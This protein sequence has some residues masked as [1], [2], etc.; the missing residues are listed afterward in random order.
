LS[1]NPQDYTLPVP[2]IGPPP[3]PDTP[4]ANRITSKAG[5]S[6]Q[7]LI[8]FS[9]E[10][11]V[12]PAVTLGIV[13]HGENYG[14]Q[15]Y[16]QGP[17]PKGARGSGQ[18]M[19]KT[20]ER[21]GKA[22]GVHPAEILHNPETNDRATV[23]EIKR[24]LTRNR[25]HEDPIGATAVGYNA[26]EGEIGRYN[27]QTG[28]H[29]FKETREYAARVKAALPQLDS[30]M[31][32]LIER[33]KNRPANSTKTTPGASPNTSVQTPAQGPE[34]PGV[35]M[36]P[37][38]GGAQTP[39]S[40]TPMRDTGSSR[41][42]QSR[43]TGT[44]SV[45]SI[46]EP[47]PPG[48][49]PSNRVTSGPPSENLT[50]TGPLP[51]P[52]I[53]QSGI[54]AAAPP[55]ATPAP[56]PPPATPER[57]QRVKARID[58]LA[59]AM[60]RLKPTA[61]EGGQASGIVYQ[62]LQ[63]EHN[64]LV[65][66]HNA[67]LPELNAKSQMK[68]G[69]AA[70]GTTRTAEPSRSSILANDAI[71][72]P[73]TGQSN[74][75]ETD[76]PATEDE[77]YRNWYA[78]RQSGDRTRA[79]AVGDA[80]LKYYPNGKYTR[81][82][83]ESRLTSEQRAQTGGAGGQIRVEEIE[84]LRKSGLDDATILTKVQDHVMRQLG[85]KDDEIY[86]LTQ[87]YGHH[88]LA[89][90]V[91]GGTDAAASLNSIIEQG[92][93][94]G[95]LA[96]F[97]VL[98]ETMQELARDK[99]MLRPGDAM[100][101]QAKASSPHSGFL[102]FLTEVGTAKDVPGPIQEAALELANHP[103]AIGVIDSLAAGGIK[104]GAEVFQGAANL[105]HFI[106][107][108][109]PAGAVTQAALQ[110][111]SGQL[112]DMGVNLG[113]QGG[114]PNLEY[115]S[116]LLMHL[117]RAYA[118]MEAG[119]VAFEGVAAP[120]EAGTALATGAETTAPTAERMLY[121]GIGESPHI[122]ST[123]ALGAEGAAMQGHKGTGPAVI[124]GLLSAGPYGVAFGEAGSALG[125]A[126]RDTTTG[127][128]L[129][130]EELAARA[131]A[132]GTKQE[133]INAAG[134]FLARKLTAEVT[135][136]ATGEAAK[137]G[138]F[139]ATSAATIAA[140]EGRPM[141]K[142]ELIE[143][144][145]LG[146]GLGIVP[147]IADFAGIPGEVKGVKAEAAR[148]S[149][150]AGIFGAKDVTRR[151]PERQVEGEVPGTDL[152]RRAGEPPAQPSSK[153]NTEGISKPSPVS[154]SGVAPVEGA[155]PPSSK[156]SSSAGA[157]GAA[158]AVEESGGGTAVNPPPTSPFKKET[159]NV[160]DQT[161]ETKPGETD[162]A[163]KPPSIEAGSE[164]S[165]AEAP[166][167]KFSSTQVNLS[168]PV[169]K[170]ITRLAAK[171]PDQDLAA[172]GREEEPHITV[173]Y[174]LHGDDAEAVR[175]V[176]ANEPPIK[177]KL[178]STSIFPGKN[179]ADYD[180]V[181]VDV[182]SPD[183][184]RLNKMIAALPHTDTHPTYQ[185]HITLA[186]VKPGLGKKY[187]GD[188][189]LEGKEV[190]LD[191][192]VFWDTEDG[193]T[194]IKLKG[195]AKELQSTAA[196]KAAE[197]PVLRKPTDADLEEL[198]RDV[199]ADVEKPAEKPAVAAPR[200]Y[201]ASGMLAAATSKAKPA[202]EA[203]LPPVEKPA[204]KPKTENQLKRAA[205]I[206]ELKKH[207][208]EGATGGKS[209]TAQ[210]VAYHT[211]QSAEWVPDRQ[212]L[213]L[214]ATGGQMLDAVRAHVGK[215]TQQKAAG[216]QFT[217][218]TAALYSR[219]AVQIAKT[220]TGQ[221][222]LDLLKLANELSRA[223]K[224]AKEIVAVVK[225]GM[226]TRETLT[227]ERIHKALGLLFREHG[228]LIPAEK[229]AKLPHYDAIN[230][231]LVDKGYD[232]NPHVMSVEAITHIGAGQ[233]EQLGITLEQ[234]SDFAEGYF[235]LVAETYGAKWLD[236]FTSLKGRYAAIKRRVQ[237]QSGSG[238]GVGQ[239]VSEGR[240]RGIEGVHPE[241]G[242]GGEELAWHASPYTFDRFTLDHIGEGEGAQS[243]GWGLYFAGAKEVGQFYKEKFQPGRGSSP[244]DIAGRVLDSIGRDRPNSKV[245]AVKEL[246][247]RADRID[248]PVFK[249]TMA[250][251][252]AAV[253][254]GTASARLYKVDLAPKEEDYLLW[255]APLYS[256]S[257]KVQA[258]LKGA[259]HEIV[260][261]KHLS[262]AQL[263]DRSTRFFYSGRFKT[264]WA[265]DIG[266]RDSLR[267]AADAYQAGKDAFLGYLE[268]AEGMSFFDNYIL[269]IGSTTGEQFYHKLAQQLEQ[270]RTLGKA[271]LQWSAKVSDP[272]AASKRLLSLGIKGIKYLDQGSRSKGEGSHN[273]VIFDG[274]DIA[275]QS[276]ED[277]VPP[278]PKQVAMMVKI[279]ASYVD[280]GITDF[281]QAAEQFQE[282]YGE[283]SRDLDRHLEL[284]WQK[285]K[286]RFYP[287]ISDAGRVADILKTKPKTADHSEAFA[288]SHP[289]WE[290]GGQAP[291]KEVPEWAKTAEGSQRHALEM[292]ARAI[293][294]ANT[295]ILK[296][297]ILP[298]GKPLT[299]E[300]RTQM[301]AENGHWR[302]VL[303][304]PAEAV[305][306]AVLS[307]DKKE[308]S[309][310]I[311]EEGKPAEAPPPAN[312]PT[313]TTAPE[314]LDEAVANYQRTTPAKG[315]PEREAVAG[316]IHDIE[317]SAKRPTKLPPYGPRR[318]AYMKKEEARSA[319]DAARVKELRNIRGRAVLE[320]TVETG[321]PE[322]QL[323]AL[324]QLKG[325]D[326]YDELKP[327]AKKRLLVEG[328]SEEAATREA[329][330][331]A[332]EVAQNP[333]S[334]TYAFSAA[335]D[336]AVTRARRTEAH[337]ELDKL[338]LTGS[339]RQKYARDIDRQFGP[340]TKILAKAKAEVETRDK[341]ARAAKKKE[342]DEQAARRTRGAERLKTPLSDEDRAAIQE[343]QKL[344]E[345]IGVA[346]EQQAKNPQSTIKPSMRSTLAERGLIERGEVTAKG[347]R[348]LAA[349]DLIAAGLPISDYRPGA[350]NLPKP[351]AGWMTGQVNGAKWYTD[352]HF[353]MKGE[354]PKGPLA[355]RSPDMQ[356]MVPDE[357]KGSMTVIKPIGFSQS[358]RAQ[359]EAIWFNGKI[360]AQSA[361][362]DHITKK[363]KAIEWRSTNP[364]KS[365]RPIYGY[366][367]G[368]LVAVLMPLRIKDVPDV[369]EAIA[370]GAPEPKKVTKPKAK[371]PAPPVVEAAPE[372]NPEITEQPNP[373]A[374]AVDRHAAALDA[375]PDNLT[376]AEHKAEVKRIE[377][378]FNEATKEV[379][380]EKGTA[381]LDL[382]PGPDQDSMLAKILNTYADEGI[383]TFE[384]ALN[385]F[386]GDYGEGARDLEPE[387][388]AA[389]QKLKE[390]HYSTRQPR[391]EEGHF[392]GSPEETGRSGERGAV[393][394]DV[395]GATDAAEALKKVA[396]TIRSGRDDFRNL[397]NPSVRG[398]AARHTAL[399]V[400]ERAADRQRSVDQ[401]TKAVDDLRNKVFAK[402]KPA[403]NYMFIDRMEHG[404]GQ[405]S[406]DL[407]V[408]SGM[409]RDIM[410]TDRQ[411]VQDLGTG[412]LEHFIENYY[413]RYWEKRK[414]GPTPAAQG[415]AKAPLEGPKSFTKRRSYEYFMDGIAAGETPLSDNP[416]DFLLWKHAEMQKYIESH[417]NLN[418][419][420]SDGMAIFAHTRA[421]APEGW[422]TPKDNLFAVW[423]RGE[424]GELI[425]R[426]HYYL[427]EEA[428]RIFDNYTSQGLRNK[429]W[430]RGY[431]GAANL[432]NQM[433]LGLSFYHAG[434]VSLDSMISNFALGIYQLTHGNPIQAAKTAAQ[435][436]VAPFTYVRMGRRMRKQW[437]DP[438]TH[439]ELEPIVDAWIAGG[440]RSSM[441]RFYHTEMSRKMAD[442]FKQ[443][444]LPGLVKGLLRA[445]FALVE[446]VAWPVMEWMVPN[447]KAGAVGKMAEYE[448][449]R[450]GPDAT[451]E[452]IRD[453]MAKV[454]DSVDN[455]M[456]QMIYDNLFWNK[457]AK[458]LGM[459][460]VR[461][462][463][464]NIGDIREVGGGGV[465]ALIA[466]KRIATGKAPE[467]T[468]RM[469]YVLALP[470]IVGLIG[471]V[472][473]YLLT[474]KGPK[475]LK[476]YFY[477]PTGN[478]DENG[479]P[480]RIQL[481]SYVKDLYPLVT[482]PGIGGKITKAG[483]M[484]QHKIHPLLNTLFE[485]YRNKDFFGTEI[486]NEDDPFV[487]QAKD[488]LAHVA[489]SLSPLGVRGLMRERERG[490]S[491][492][493]QALPM[494]GITPA[495]RYVNQTTTQ[496]LMEEYLDSVRP[497]GVR[498]KA[499]AEALAIMREIARAERSGKPV[500]QAKV[501]K[502][503]AD[504]VLKPDDL[505]EATRRGRLSTTQSLFQ[506]LPYEKAQQIY[507]GAPE[508]E[509]RELL[510]LLQ[511]K[512][513]N[514]NQSGSTGARTPSVPSIMRGGSHAPSPSHSG[515][516][517]ITR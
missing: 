306:V 363:Y 37:E 102:S 430:F 175:K 496:Q 338:D 374:E 76:V 286:E 353:M 195:T 247:N 351:Y 222:K 69:T 512:L 453:A 411:Q 190:T 188:A 440:G 28:Y 142:E 180:V 205:L 91:K 9:L 305:K 78:A 343:F 456:G 266:I 448:L 68:G 202:K 94:N 49:Q 382:M 428:V 304:E 364:D 469:S 475:E 348:L 295:G 336:R 86:A 396:A 393:A 468:H 8:H 399:M 109:T 45:P 200:N 162:K 255:D 223:A 395:L 54:F 379:E 57:L 149:N 412:K 229:V 114:H 310:L 445:P 483:E 397:F 390:P 105:A 279:L 436:A 402:A 63:D 194:E 414:T 14:K 460:T 375:I 34:K 252:I 417:R 312:K 64:R 261:R 110:T 341:E 493:K 12:D 387:L 11:G 497:Q 507:D 294:H 372:T 394:A 288:A 301:E 287:D 230:L 443:G 492:I 133:A 212:V 166:E 131:L 50:A 186:Y 56:R 487:Q 204:E 227:H 517:R 367:K 329:N 365:D 407:N 284:A 444:T 316:E 226:A 144:A 15:K 473:T 435:T 13:E 27:S 228:R 256:Q 233:R 409:F 309:R 98:P 505:K 145:V 123:L 240:T 25:D 29:P 155:T 99:A 259:G 442:A 231:G 391:T 211:G 237:E 207:R 191:S 151:G 85:W 77:F 160:S 244:K 185:P 3:A 370:E 429:L 337:G 416:V 119:G 95:G 253:R 400:R 108:G 97:R 339:Q 357:A 80:Y 218:Q 441:D 197:K 262:D 282:D 380:P 92:N 278:D 425:Q 161:A 124:G 463:G 307:G 283:G 388:E 184:H 474:G 462:L 513:Q 103:D 330:G 129:P 381:L 232:D 285:L 83:T 383:E 39:T 504:G 359:F 268:T 276:M 511:K 128:I 134:R 249:K 210:G 193:Q 482:Q 121:E 514:Q 59:G 111:L 189:S 457:A 53:T 327:I 43:I 265:E 217:N 216:S 461:S 403:D 331:V 66:A 486:R 439:Q 51:E 410:D 55:A 87:K 20:A 113:Q 169:A 136:L 476:D 219:A 116:R 137:Q 132:A 494:I 350:G 31:R 300:R 418:E 42:G 208:G 209:L 215:K 398:S 158:S 214:N 248:D 260:E 251:A 235:K 385:Q 141:T 23:F 491:I 408:A 17:S 67:M 447:M 297:G 241:G 5:D 170:E 213:A 464:W 74:Q 354:P 303:A 368:E 277:L 75:A 419:L 270:E 421:D 318:D 470:A 484:A 423:S 434:F 290:A 41:I 405:A 371:A 115:S 139:L 299:A 257:D 335:I 427:P 201:P 509:K 488:E 65:E 332:G 490:A 340:Y 431:L 384:E 117:L 71:V 254:D 126:L 82:I 289:G 438:G 242:A 347:N 454:V 44:L 154:P 220:L 118:T 7:R 415:H 269:R 477:P 296:S 275:I 100:V 130:A 292:Q 21:L 61:E 24:L 10:Q 112:A 89:N 506:Q 258:A 40:N 281:K 293:L 4:P 32:P 47:P 346:F 165:Q 182:D 308:V 106:A 246:Q 120:A 19:P 373:M 467:M 317:Q 386:R 72:T 479:D 224:G 245:L 480:E 344:P 449:R 107:G 499:R 250:D 273:Y 459:A 2:A 81:P 172:D 221:P 502:A 84:R 196:S 413:P 30:E 96:E 334:E 358:E 342:A 478:T 291:T 168:G 164:S 362:V 140:A 458:D 355:E 406:P 274:A 298:N 138:L 271:D 401:V 352:G 515:V 471:A 171:I 234:A 125:M 178:G 146:I 263:F 199:I 192:I 177:V 6:R 90:M 157:T 325:K 135:G 508:N 324:A 481:P 377:A 36:G 206:E 378:E 472:L 495:P 104:D 156:K 70:R 376:R 503:L 345:G 1:G 323:A 500:D 404:L 426:G 432:V 127:A 452:Q 498:T 446:K 243:Y 280:E 315:T 18:I 360:A 33:W 62:K 198:T 326:A 88:P 153:Q 152:V 489:K 311:T 163:G 485:M 361:L 183:L 422:T 333:A 328:L 79:R 93:S 236:A 143:Q 58:Q 349:R 203:P 159:P 451:R 150:E 433:Q 272:E 302:E 167:R 420:K 264:L 181:K 366:D 267:P 179:G 356:R 122:G 465:D 101:Q 48:Q 26:G 516:R 225:R 174:G 22:M 450:L 437:I 322:N 466:G 369:I 510:P 424:N 392:D 321:E 187:E 389:W 60:E 320:D 147:H 238:S 319:K 313:R 46:G 73:K 148:L 314:D 38:F 52:T 176:I 455:R 501:Q 173:R 35:V 16:A 239:G